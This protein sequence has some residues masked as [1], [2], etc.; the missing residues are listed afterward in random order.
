MP[1]RGRPERLRQG[2]HEVIDV[3]ANLLAVVLLGAMLGRSKQAL[4]GR[5]CLD[6]ADGVAQRLRSLVRVRSDGP[7]LRQRAVG[8][9]RNRVR[10][11]RSS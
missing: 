10:A 7:P 4:M 11:G 1:D 9:E 3:R 5:N 2:S 6:G 8:G